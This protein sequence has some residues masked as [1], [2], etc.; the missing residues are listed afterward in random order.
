MIP[1]RFI[2][3]PPVSRLRTH[4]T[5]TRPVSLFIFHFTRKR[6][7][8]DE[9]G[10]RYT[11]TEYDFIAAETIPILHRSEHDA[12]TSSFPSDYALQLISP[13]LMH[14]GR[15]KALLLFAENSFF[16]LRL[17]IS[18]PIMFIIYSLGLLLTKK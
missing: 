10:M 12:Q 5:P 8:S 2:S 14:V 15:R 7:K 1:R 4:A 13:F 18:A 11:L 17:S 3:Y 9:C 6:E 16:M